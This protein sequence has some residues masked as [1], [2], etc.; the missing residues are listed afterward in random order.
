[1]VGLIT[2]F[3]Q[4]RYH[5]HRIGVITESPVCRLCGEEDI[6]FE[7]EALAGRRLSIFGTHLLEDAPT[8]ETLAEDLLNLVRGKGILD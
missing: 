5:L 7:C 3:C 4:L 2:G 8:G 1:M 6:A